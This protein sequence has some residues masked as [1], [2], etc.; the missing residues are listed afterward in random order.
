MAWCFGGNSAGDNLFIFNSK[1]MNVLKIIA[2]FFD[3]TDPHYWMPLVFKTVAILAAF[4][5]VRRYRPRWRYPVY[6]LLLVLAIRMALFGQYFSWEFY[7]DRLNIDEVGWRQQSALYVEYY[8]FFKYARPVKYLAVGSSQTYVIYMS[9][10]KKHRDLRVFNLAG[11]APLDLYL[12][13]RYI[14]ARNPGHILLYLSEFDMAK[15]P[16][17]DAAKIG[18]YQGPS[19]WKIWPVL[20][21]I[22]K[23]TRSQTD[24]K[25][26][27]AGEFLPEYKY[28]FI[29]KGFTDKWMNKNKALDIR[30]LAEELSPNALQMVVNARQMVEDMDER[31]IKY[32]SYFLAEFLKYCKDRALE[33]IIV[34]GQYNPMA[35]N[36]KSILLNKSTLKELE[37]L[38]REFDNVV[39]IP[40]ADIMDFNR[41]DYNDVMHVNPEAGYRFA[42]HLIR[43]LETPSTP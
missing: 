20:S 13:R 25:E 30:P 8:K 16:R 33:V 12:Y 28:S 43:K 23:Q 26:M 35:W 11:M 15:A 41:D 3:V 38:D 37:R 21:D 6:A 19:F 22:A 34:E 14:S 31:W 29:F 39:F 36:E 17:L 4:W 18:P 9:Y 27:I 7:K 1:I 10:S 24:L 40:R 32:N 2:D 5:L 42:E